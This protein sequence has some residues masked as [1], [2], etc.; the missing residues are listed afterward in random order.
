MILKNYYYLKIV[1]ICYFNEK[2]HDAKKI[3]KIDYIIF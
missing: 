3:L 1:K 2:Q